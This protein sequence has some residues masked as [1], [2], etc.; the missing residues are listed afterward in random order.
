MDK[1]VAVDKNASEYVMKTN[2]MGDIKL[3]V[4]KAHN[5]KLY[6]CFV[7]KLQSGKYGNLSSFVTFG[8]NLQNGQEKFANLT[9]LEQVYVIVQILRFFKCDAQTADIKLVGG[10]AASGRIYLNGNITDVDFQLI[11]QS[12]CGLT[13]RTRKL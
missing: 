11:D 7:E 1:N 5:E 6:D 10:S 4:D 2:R 12:P 8:K 9:T 13:V 3:V